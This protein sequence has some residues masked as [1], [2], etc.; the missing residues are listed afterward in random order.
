MFLRLKRNFLYNASYTVNYNNVKQFIYYSNIKFHLFRVTA[1]DLLRISTIYKN[2]N[3][4]N[5][6]FI[7]HIHIY[8][9]YE[10]NVLNNIVVINTTVF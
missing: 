3:V 10:L 1:W 5:L 7:P 2:I 8:K 6:D 9:S 4:N